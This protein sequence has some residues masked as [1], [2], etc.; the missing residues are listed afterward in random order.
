MEKKE[1]ARDTQRAT[2]KPD[3][4]WNDINEIKRRTT[5]LPRKQLIIYSFPC[6]RSCF[7]LSQS[8]DGDSEAEMEGR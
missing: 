8:S 4:T 3:Y 1:L 5:T 2:Q 6:L 7:E